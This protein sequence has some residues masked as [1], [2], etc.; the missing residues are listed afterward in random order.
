MWDLHTV[1]RLQ[2]EIAASWRSHD[3]CLIKGAPLPT[4]TA[5][6]Q[7]LIWID[8]GVSVQNP[9]LP[10]ALQ[11][12]FCHSEREVMLS[13]WAHLFSCISWPCG[14][15]QSVCLAVAASAE[16]LWEQDMSSL[17]WQRKSLFQMQIVYINWLLINNIGL[18]N[19]S[20]SF[21]TAAVYFTSCCGS[22]IPLC[23]AFCL[24]LQTKRVLTGIFIVC[25]NFPN[26]RHKARLW[27]HIN[28]SYYH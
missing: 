6:C 15:F 18:M 16:K 9:Q 14:A 10:S 20:C 11:T 25:L 12:H 7:C 5:F 24:Q 4:P 13:S 26:N 8:A 1:P 22:L 21:M 17:L 27:V 3:H 2:W 19:Q 28:A 23:M